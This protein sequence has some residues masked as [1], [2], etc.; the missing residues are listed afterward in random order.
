MVKNGGKTFKEL[1]P[2]INTQSDENNSNNS[3]K[4]IDAKKE[5][6]EYQISFL[7]TTDVTPTRKQA[8]ID[9]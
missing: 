5:P 7:N 8:Y 4:P 6:Y 2:D 3:T 1:H 9:L